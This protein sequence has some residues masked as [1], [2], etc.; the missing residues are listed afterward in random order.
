MKRFQMSL[1]TVQ[2]KLT[3]LLMIFSSF[4]LAQKIELDQTID[5]PTGITEERSQFL[6]ELLNDPDTE[7]LHYFDTKELLGHLL[8]DKEVTSID[9]SIDEANLPIEV[10]LNQTDNLG[11]QFWYGRSRDEKNLLGLYTHPENPYLAGFIQSSRGNYEIHAVSKGVSAL[12]RVTPRLSGEICGIKDPD[13]EPPT[14]PIDEQFELCDH[15]ADCTAEVDVLVFIPQD[16]LPNL[17]AQ[18]LSHFERWFYIMAGLN[19][20]PA[21]L[22]NTGIDGIT[23]N[24]HFESIDFEYPTDLDAEEVIK[25][26]VNQVGSYRTSVG[27]DLA[28]MLSATNLDGFIAGIV[29][30]LGPFVGN[31]FAIIHIEEMFAPRWTFAHEMGHL[32][33][34]RHNRTYIGNCTFSCDLDADDEHPC[35]HGVRFGF[36]EIDRT[37]MA[38]M[39]G[40]NALPSSERMLQFSDV[41]GIG[42]DINSNGTTIE[43][44]GCIVA[45][46]MTPQPM[47]VELNPVQYPICIDD[48]QFSV[49]ATVFEASIVLPGHPP[50]T[51]E[52]SVSQ[53][54]ITPNGD[55]SSATVQFNCAVACTI[56]VTCTVTSDD[57]EVVTTSIDVSIEEGVCSGGGGGQN[58]VSNDN[59]QV[60]LGK[61]KMLNKENTI[62]S[63]SPNPV[64][65]LLYLDIPL[66]A[67]FN[68]TIY[69]LSGRIQLEQLEADR[70]N[71]IDV[72]TLNKGIHFIKVSTSTEDT[73]L[74]FIKQ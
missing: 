47:S 67:S 7:V 56:S 44:M 4:L 63:I 32:F 59:K 60:V 38:V 1:P 17:I 24:W 3:C 40:D 19:T 8:S 41:D 70:T 62:I 34:G 50:Y 65:T 31:A 28:I 49:V 6:D 48:G 20:F 64:S 15:D 10:M 29:N 52:W 73:I 58:L 37:T 36:G 53:G 68:Y 33:G 27:A 54:T 46:Y 2:Y 9:L 42:D 35:S 30:G 21:A 22:A 45:N 5:R 12:R 71:T 66:D 55:G 16:V 74:R 14:P 39:G 61:H 25:A 69:D 26:F 43:I 51:Y 23:I 57:G 72:S 18:G 13:P 11:G